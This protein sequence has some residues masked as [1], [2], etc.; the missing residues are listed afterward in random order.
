VVGAG[1]KYW[2]LGGGGNGECMG[3]ACMG[4]ACMGGACMGG[5]CMGGGCECCGCPG[6]GPA[7]CPGRIMGVPPPD[8]RAARG[9]WLVDHA[10][11]QSVIPIYF[12]SSHKKC[13]H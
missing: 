5:A 4:G 6:P 10:V 7:I 2:T 8:N 11:A 9:T 12:S 1:K 3:G 13:Q